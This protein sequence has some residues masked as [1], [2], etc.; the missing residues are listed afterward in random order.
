MY[1]WN[2]EQVMIRDAVRKFI[3]KEIKPKLEEI[4]HGDSPPY[5]LIRRMLSTFGM[6]V[7]ARENFQRQIEFEKLTE[8]ARAKGQEP[9]AKKRREGGDGSLM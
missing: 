7:M 8:E 3:E 1:Q 6:D 5:P 4:E 2:E 9:P